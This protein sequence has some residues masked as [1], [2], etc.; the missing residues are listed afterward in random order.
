LLLSGANPVQA[1]SKGDFPIHLAAQHGLDEVVLALVQKGVDLNRVNTRGQTP[2]DVAL[3]WDHVATM[4]VLLSD[5]ADPNTHDLTHLA[6]HK[7]NAAAI[8]ALF[9]AGAD[10]ERRDG[11]IGLTPLH[12]AANFGKCTAS[13]L[14]LLQLGANVNSKNERGE[15]P[16]YTA[17]LFG[18]DDA[19]DLL[20]RWGADETTVNS[21]GE[22]VASMVI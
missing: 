2:L 4:K 12:F 8:R 18:H 17:C 7:N 6:T 10:I 16:L 11:L 3:W 1:G 20:L 21:H 9:E 13:M 19:V 15:N 14:T 5:G 22:T